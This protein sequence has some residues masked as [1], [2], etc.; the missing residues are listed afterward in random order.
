MFDLRKQEGANRQVMSGSAGRGGGR[1]CVYTH[2][3]RSCS[4]MTIDRRSPV[5]PGRSTPGFRRPGRHRVHRTRT[6]GGLGEG[7][8][9]FVACLSR[10]PLT[11]HP[12]LDGREAGGGSRRA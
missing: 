7:G 9:S 11:T 4:R 3:M 2:F 12:F 5:I 6:G 8:G 1:G 10:L